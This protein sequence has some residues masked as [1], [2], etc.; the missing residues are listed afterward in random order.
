MTPASATDGRFRIHFV[1]IGNLCR[2]PTA[3]IAFRK[4]LPVALGAAA[5]LERLPSFE[6][7]VQRRWPSVEKARRLLGWEAQISLH[8]GVAQTAAWLRT[9]RPEKKQSP[10]HR[11]FGLCRTAGLPLQ[12]PEFRTS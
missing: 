10:L 3:E 1:C 6:V 9:R 4:L 2:S 11:P 12:N 7:D 5:Y 8:D